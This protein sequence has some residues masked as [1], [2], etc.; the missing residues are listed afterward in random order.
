[1]TALMWRTLHLTAWSWLRVP[2]NGN[3]AWEPV[4]AVTSS[5]GSVVENFAHVSQRLAPVESVIVVRGALGSSSDPAHRVGNEGLAGQYAPCPRGVE[6]GEQAQGEVQHRRV[7][8]RPVATL[9]RPGLLSR[10]LRQKLTVCIP[11]ENHHD[12]TVLA[13]LIDAGRVL[14]AIDRVYPLA[15]T[16]EAI[17]YLVGGQASR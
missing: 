13:E 14:P 17:R 8:L 6:V 5:S 7:T 16:A 2:L 11:N 3:H 9:H 4:Y 10:F 1:M 12:M 15:D